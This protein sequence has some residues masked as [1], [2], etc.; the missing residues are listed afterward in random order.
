MIA[1]VA[2]ACLLGLSLHHTNLPSQ[3][4]R[5]TTSSQFFASLSPHTTLPSLRPS[6]QVLN[7]Q[8]QTC[9][10]SII[11]IPPLFHH[12]F[13][14]SLRHSIPSL[15]WSHH[16]CQ[17][18]PLRSRIPKSI[19]TTFGGPDNNSICPSFTRADGTPQY[20]CACN[21]CGRRKSQLGPPSTPPSAQPPPSLAT[22]ISMDQTLTPSAPL[23]GLPT[24]P[25]TAVPSLLP[26]LSNPNQPNFY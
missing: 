24:T 10:Q 9:R 5:I 7:V 17:R 2:L 11:H 22:P 4:R 12:R 3:Q 21:H 6:P 25:A 19:D 26:S 13:L 15:R 1:I 16:E 23:S 18:R 8:Q 14:P 20:C